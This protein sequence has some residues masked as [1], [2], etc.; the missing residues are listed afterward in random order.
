LKK[1]N[2]LIWI[3]AGAL[4]LFYTRTD[5]R[6]GQVS[7]NET[8]IK[9]YDPKY[10]PDQS[11]ADYLIFRAMISGKAKMAV[12]GSSVTKGS[13]S[14]NQSKTW[15]G[16]IEENLRNTNPALE[17]FLIS[18]HGYSGYTSVRLLEDNVTAPILKEQPDV[19]FIET[20][21]INNHNKN[22]SLEDTFISFHSLYDMYSRSLPDT[23]IVFLSPNPCTENT[24]GPPLNQ[25]G[26]TFTDYVKRTETYIKEQKWAYFDTHDAM[27]NFMAEKNISLSSTLKD[28]IHP[29]DRGYKIWADVLWRFM[30]QT[31]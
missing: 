28:G 7:A 19:L 18:N 13:G 3:V 17:Q 9:T 14:S 31:Q 23:R 27:L 21:V 11:L 10:N 15:R 29:N 16:R 6:E 5:T 12:T 30:Q 2:W 26:L 25:F 24:F 20:S 4:L 8:L 22:V 1:W